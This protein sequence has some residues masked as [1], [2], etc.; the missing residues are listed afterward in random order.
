MSK[1]SKTSIINFIKDINKGLIKR[2]LYSEPTSERK[3]DEGIKYVVGKTFDT[4]FNEHL[5]ARSKALLQSCID[6]P[7]SVETFEKE[8]QYCNA[9]K[10]D[11]ADHKEIIFICKV[12][13]DAN[14]QRSPFFFVG[15]KRKLM[16]QLIKLFPA[17]INNYYEP[18]CGGGSSFLNKA[19]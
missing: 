16:P 12:K 14:M 3:I 4:I 13:K 5:S 10:T 15:D 1:E 7:L 9:G 17:Y 6:E 8:H 19:L 18:F 2:D 11:L